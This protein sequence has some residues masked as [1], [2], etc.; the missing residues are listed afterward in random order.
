[1]EQQA[2]NRGGEQQATTLAARSLAVADAAADVAA[3][4]VRNHEDT[5]RAQVRCCLAPL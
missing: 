4:R 3:A 5:V 1:M 2:A